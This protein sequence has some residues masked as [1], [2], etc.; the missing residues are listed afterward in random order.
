[1]YTYTYTH[2]HT[3]I[4]LQKLTHTLSLSLSHTHTHKHTQT[5]QLHWQPSRAWR[6]TAL[7]SICK[8]EKLEKLFNFLPTLGRPLYFCLATRTLTLFLL[9]GVD[10]SQVRCDLL[11]PLQILS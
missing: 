6:L 1:M 7:H 2:T 3:H 9:K 4:Q 8:L 11:T 5:H 10:V